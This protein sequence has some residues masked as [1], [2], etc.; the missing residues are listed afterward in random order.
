MDK[1][2]HLTKANH[3]SEWDPNQPEGVYLETPRLAVGEF[4]HE[5][6]AVQEPMRPLGRPGC[7]EACEN[8]ADGV[9]VKWLEKDSKDSISVRNNPFSI[10]EKVKLKS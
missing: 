3:S 4:I 8:R 10:L 1:G 7:E 5:L 6:V 9:L 2:D